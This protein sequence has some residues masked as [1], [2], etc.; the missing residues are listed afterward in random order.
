L[1]LIQGEDEVVAA[2]YGRTAVEPVRFPL[3]HQGET[4]GH[5][6]AGPRA[7][8][9]KLTPAET[10]LLEDV[11]LQAAIAAHAVRLTADLQQ[12]RE[13]LVTAREEER[14]RLRRDLH[15]GLGPALAGLML[16]VEAAKDATAADP[17]G[18]EA[19]LSE[20]K[21]DIQGTLTDV[22]RLVYN[23]RPPALDE[24]G[25]AGAMRDY[26]LQGTWPASLCVTLEGPE[27]LP[28]LPAAVE[29][30]AYRVVQE[31]VTNVVRHAQ[32]RRCTVRLG[33]ER[34]FLH[35]DVEDDGRGLPAGWRAGV[36]ITAMRERAAELGGSFAIEA[37][38]AGGTR[39]VARLPI[40]L[41]R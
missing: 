9:E 34:D 39:L 24:F 15:D 41:R 23:L 38:R 14:R 19:L 37:P 11:A 5:L 32:A 12:S 40:G 29:V 8:G 30:A 18:A 33:L 7:P 13:R 27:S 28:P 35:V 25:L 10:R 21:T 6:L 36:G 31:A 2:D 16:K 1:T 17:A 20:L 3:V 26:L 4:I 22:R